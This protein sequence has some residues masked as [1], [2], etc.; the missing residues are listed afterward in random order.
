[1]S[2]QFIIRDDD[3]CYFT[4]PSD[5]ASLYADIWSSFP[6]TFAAVPWQS[7]A[8]A[9]HVPLAFWH[10]TRCFPL[11][12]NTELVSL[13]KAQLAN[14]CIDI[15]LHGIHHTYA[16][17]RNQIVPELTDFKGDFGKAVMSG[18]QYLDDLFGT[19]IKVFVPPSNTLRSDLAQILIAQGWN[20]LNLPGLRRN[21][22]PALSLQH[23]IGRIRRLLSFIREGVDMSAPLVW[24]TR[25]EV[26]GFPLTPTT[27]LEKLK[28]AFRLATENGH[29]FVL[30]THYWEHRSFLP[31]EEG[32]CQYDLL[33]DFLD[34]VSR[35]DI[36][37]IPARDLKLCK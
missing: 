6:I 22:R 37:P 32:R 4:D 21:T 30:A 36:K 10:T 14:D 17:K 8:F 7:G 23:Q 25:W 18:K 15:A 31:N 33:R 27:N 34:Y 2:T 9:G 35:F 28:H 3:L 19:D 11:G 12:E 29:P 24:P 26:G 20:L 5:L 16:I 13:V 1:M